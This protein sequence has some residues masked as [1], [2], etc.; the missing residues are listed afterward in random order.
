MSKSTPKPHSR[1]AADRPKKIHLDFPLTPYARGAWVK[2]NSW[3]DL[4]VREVGQ[5]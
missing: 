2:E 1:K 4:L 5:S 3:Q